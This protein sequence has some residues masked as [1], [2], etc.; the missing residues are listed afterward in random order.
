MINLNKRSS[1]ENDAVA[2]MV[3]S[4][5]QTPQRAIKDTIVD[6]ELRHCFLKAQRFALKTKIVSRS[7]QVDRRAASVHAN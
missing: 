3:D 2:K 4:M 1:W 5:C 7:V 6:A